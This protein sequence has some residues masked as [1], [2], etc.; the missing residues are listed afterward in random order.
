[1]S[2][3]ICRST[4]YKTSFEKQPMVLDFPFSM[5]LNDM[6]HSNYPLSRSNG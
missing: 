5:K 3:Y 6:K 1:M 4:Y 2:K